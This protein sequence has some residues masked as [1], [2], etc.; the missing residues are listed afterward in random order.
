M[1]LNEYIKEVNE[2]EKVFGNAFRTVA[3]MI[4]GEPGIMKKVTVNGRTT[5]DDKIFR[6]SK[7]TFLLTS[8][9]NLR[10]K[11]TPKTG[12]PMRVRNRS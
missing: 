7:S 6:S 11:Q 1:T 2:R 3:R 8:F 12:T 4:L 10:N 9:R 5:Y